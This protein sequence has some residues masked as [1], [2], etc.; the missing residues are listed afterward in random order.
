MI[1]IGIFEG[2]KRENGIYVYD[3]KSNENNNK[4]YIYLIKYIHYNYIHNILFGLL[5][6]VI[7]M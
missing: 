2:M 5:L 1:A 7:K 4:K 6:S 3:N